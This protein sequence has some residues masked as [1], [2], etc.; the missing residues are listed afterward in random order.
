MNEATWIIILGLGLDIIGALLIIGPLRQRKY[1]RKRII[2]TFQEIFGEIEKLQEGKT[3]MPSPETNKERID[4]I[5]ENL[6]EREIEEIKGYKKLSWGI[7][8]LILGFIL[9]IIGNW[10]QNPPL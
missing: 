3:E 5:A 10:F 9:Q 7:A 8:I 2:K 4:R 6:S 1:L